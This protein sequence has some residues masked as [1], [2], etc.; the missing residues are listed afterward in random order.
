[1]MMPM[2]SQTTEYALRAAVCLAGRDGAPL[3]ARQLARRTHVPF[4]YLQKVLRA[5]VHSELVRARRGPH[6]GFTLARKPQ[7]LS[8]LDVVNAVDPIARVHKCPLRLKEHAEQLC[9]LHRRLDDAA[10]AV[11]KA[12]AASCLAEMALDLPKKK[13]KA[14]GGRRK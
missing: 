3:T 4:D 8:V 14:E 12:F 7:E 11:E 1:M 6:G 2:I 5:L 13:R 10:V 9:P